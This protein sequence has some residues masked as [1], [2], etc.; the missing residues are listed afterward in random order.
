VDLT[1]VA[2]EVGHAIGLAS[3]SRL[4]GS[5]AEYGDLWDVMSVYSVYYNSAGV[6]ATQT[7]YYTF[8]PGLNAVNMDIVGWLDPARVFIGSGS[9]TFRLRPLH[10]RDLPGWLAA[11]L[12]IGP[13]TIYLE[14]R[15]AD[16]WDSSI[17]RACVLAHRRSTHPGDGHPCS[18]LLLTLK[19]DPVVAPR[20]DLRQGD[21]LERGDATDPFGFYARVQV[22]QIDI[23]NQEATIS[24]YVRHRRQ[25]E[26][27]ATLYGA[28]TSDGGGLVWTPGR[29]FVKVPPRSP[30]LRLV[31]LVA[32]YESLQ[33]MS[34]ADDQ[35]GADRLSVE[36]LVKM[37]DHVTGIMS[38]RSEP[39]VP[40]PLPMRDSAE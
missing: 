26:P 15:V 22:S 28:V 6:I 38:R 11:K 1:G 29:G 32:D 3:H 13:E 20:P 40:G 25:I 2:H 23:A 19:D 8:G 4:E 33:L 39:K 10:R 18:E 5:A 35:Y 30:L 17:P 27:A 37:R 34:S 7:P 9:S 12:T 36:Q 21:S 24:V 16:G 31:E 14:F